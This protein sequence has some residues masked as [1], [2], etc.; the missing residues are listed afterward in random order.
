MDC[1]IRIR[2]VLA[3]FRNEVGLL[4]IDEFVQSDKASPIYEIS[5]IFHP[6]QIPMTVLFI[7]TKKSYLTSGIGFRRLQKTYL[8]SCL[9]SKLTK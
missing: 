7:N 5:K 9:V 6:S 3:K 2:D 4:S 1:L 8:S